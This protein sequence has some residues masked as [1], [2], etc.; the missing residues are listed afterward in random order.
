M[1]EQKSLSQGGGGGIV[2]QSLFQ[3]LGPFVLHAPPQLQLKAL[4]IIELLCR[5]P[6]TFI[7]ETHPAWILS[8][9]WQKVGFYLEREGSF[10]KQAA[11]QQ[12]CLKFF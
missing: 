4:G 2:L 11:K 1:F 12:H 5:F 7:V 8:L 6:E 10:A 3:E 9:L